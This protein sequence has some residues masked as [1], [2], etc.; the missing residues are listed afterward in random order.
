MV[1]WGCIS[2]NVRWSVEVIL[3]CYSELVRKH[4]KLWLLFWPPWYKIDM[5]MLEKIQQSAR[6]MMTRLEHLYCKKKLRKL[7]LFSL[8]KGRLKDIIN[9]Q[10]N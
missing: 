5:D 8:E 3:P 10:N 2:R 1:A 4:A 9:V 7:E 6:E